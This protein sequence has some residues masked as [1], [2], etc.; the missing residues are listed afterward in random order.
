MKTALLVGA[1]GLIGGQL[2]G[3]ILHDNHYSKVIAIS[4]MPLLITDPR[5]INVV[6]DFKSITSHADELKCDDV[7]CCYSW[8]EFEEFIV[9]HRVG[10][11]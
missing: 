4:R 1:T 8:V 10:D 2:L 3:L 7:F 11:C 9:Q 6:S 5:L